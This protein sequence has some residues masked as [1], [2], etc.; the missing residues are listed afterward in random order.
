MD[1]D[2]NDPLHTSNLEFW[3]NKPHRLEL[4][5]MSHQPED[6]V[7]FLST[8]RNLQSFSFS[9]LEMVGNKADLDPSW[10]RTALLANARDTLESMI[11]LADGYA[12][13]NS[14]EVLLILR[15]WH[16]H[17]R[18]DGDPSIS[19]LTL[20]KILPSSIVYLRL[21]IKISLDG[22]YYQAS[23]QDVADCAMHFD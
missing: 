21:H 9:P 2:P 6:H 11:I 14:R 13:Q 19:P 3:F 18:M 1:S 17:K 23:I 12:R 16:K 7:R 22:A 8:T 10:I 4:R 15:F 5:R 20:S